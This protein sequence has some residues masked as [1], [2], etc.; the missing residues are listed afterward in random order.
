M[1]EVSGREMKIGQKELKKGDGGRGKGERERRR[2]M[3]EQKRGK[4][5]K[6]WG[7]S[8]TEF[9]LYTQL[10]LYAHRQAIHNHTPFQDCKEGGGACHLGRLSGQPDHITQG[11]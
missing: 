8:I 11:L 10:L 6:V 1:K 2:E 9:C 3:R 7:T 4:R 5:N